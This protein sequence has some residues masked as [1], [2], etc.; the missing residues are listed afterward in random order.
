M[1]STMIMTNDAH[2][3]SALSTDDL[4]HEL[5]RS[6]EMTAKHI[7]YLAMIWKELEDRGEDLSDLRHG[8]AA[9]LP[10]IARS[11][12]DASLVIQYAGQKTLLGALSQL[13]IEEQRQVSESGYV[14]LVALDDN[15]QRQELQKP[16][17]KLSAGEVH[18]VF[19][20][21]GIRSSD[22]QLRLL[23]RRK[24]RSAPTKKPKHRRARRVK[25]DAQENV[26]LVSNMA[27]DLSR[28]LDALSDH[29]KV[30]LASLIEGAKS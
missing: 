19:S 6:L 30:D 25:V 2:S 16:L 27:A 1:T 5:G 21:T 10:L 14:T 8:L 24:N 20:D 26:L 9:Y 22:D 18:Q 7:T 11:K 3:L 23:D 13:P 12:L 17:S 29:Y 15:G 28:V 4:K